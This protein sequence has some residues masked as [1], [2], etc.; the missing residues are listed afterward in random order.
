MSTPPA[1]LG[2]RPCPPTYL[3]R[4]LFTGHT[5]TR[6]AFCG[7]S[8]TS[9]TPSLGVR[10]RLSPRAAHDDWNPGQLGFRYPLYAR[11]VPIRRNLKVRNFL[12]FSEI[13]PFG[14]FGQ[15]LD[16]VQNVQTDNS[17]CHGFTVRKTFLSTSPALDYEKSAIWTSVLKGFD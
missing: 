6:L 7:V 8:V 15:V 5:P 1:S 3:P 10:P 11:S 9:H 13:T 17:E 12:A 14:H 16:N 4:P 2:P